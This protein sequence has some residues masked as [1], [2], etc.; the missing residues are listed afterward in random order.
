MIPSLE[1]TQPLLLDLSEQGEPVKYLLTIHGAAN[2]RY[3][4]VDT[5][6]FPFVAADN[7]IGFF[8]DGPNGQSRMVA[9]FPTE[10]SW[11]IVCREALEFPALKA[12]AAQTKLDL[13]TQAKY[14]K[15]LYPEGNEEREEAG[16][17]VIEVPGQ[18]AK[19]STGL[20]L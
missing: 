17:H 1:H 13:E 10:T 6:K 12:L 18:P 7:V 3:L 20:Y 11:T 16:V 9:L 14:Q 8:R 15:E 5:V 2:R 19:P 4:W